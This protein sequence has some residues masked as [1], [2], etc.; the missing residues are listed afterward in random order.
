METPRISIIVPNYNHVRYLPARLESIRR[1][2][3]RDTEVILMDDASTDG[4]VE[5]LKRFA[6]ETGASLHINGKNSGSPFRQWN[7]GVKLAR[8]E[9][10]WMAESDDE[11]DPRFL[12]RMMGKL[13][14]DPDGVLAYCRSVMVNESG[15]VLDEGRSWP[16][17]ERWRSDFDA[18]G[19][20]ECRRELVIRNTIPN[21][22]GVVFRRLAY[23]AGGGALEDMRYCGD[24]VAWYRVLKSG[25]MFYCAEVLNRFRKHERSV[26]G[27]V[28]TTALPHLEAVRVLRLMLSEMEVEPLVRR[29]ALQLC[30]ARWAEYCWAGPGRWMG[31]DTRDFV[32]QLRGCGPGAALVLAK[33]FVRFGFRR[34]GGLIPVG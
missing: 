13:G 22:S 28:R 7:A 2:T 14:S 10:V 16:P 6:G 17:E 11:A 25:R 1:Q 12:E 4:S 21:A 20:E 33:A 5:L 24:W 3:Y 15:M 23:V 8:G 27:T 29:Q 34:A 30:V 18:D 26:T 32:G 19:P 9:Y 31:R